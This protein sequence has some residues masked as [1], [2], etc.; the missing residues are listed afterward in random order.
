MRRYPLLWPTVARSLQ[1]RWFSSQFSAFDNPL[2]RQLNGSVHSLE[3][4]PYTNFGGLHTPADFLP[5]FQQTKTDCL[6]IM[7]SC[8]SSSSSS[9]PLDTIRGID[10]VSDRICQVA[11][12]A[13]LTHALHTDRQWRAAASEIEMLCGDFI[14]SL[15]CHPSI[16]D[17][18]HTAVSSEVLPPVAA[19]VGHRLKAELE[20]ARLQDELAVMDTKERQLAAEYQRLALSP[21]SSLPQRQEAL[22]AL[23][24]HRQSYARARSF[25][26]YAEMSHQSGGLVYDDVSAIR[27][28]MQ[29]LEAVPSLAAPPM[30]GTLS[31][32]L[33][34]PSLPLVP[35]SSFFDGMQQLCRQMLQLDVHLCPVEDVYSQVPLWAPHTQ[36][37]RVQQLPSSEVSSSS[38]NMDQGETLGYIYVDLTRRGSNEAATYVLRSAKQKQLLPSIGNECQSSRQIPRC[39]LVLPFGVRHL[40]LREMMTACHEFGHALHNI[41]GQTEFQSMAGTRC[42]RD[43]VEI[44]ST[45]WE[46]VCGKA[47]VLRYFAP[48][49]SEDQCQAAASYLDQH[50][51]RSLKHSLLLAQF[52]M[53]LH[54]EVDLT[55]SIDRLWLQCQRGHSN[56]GQ[57]GVSYDFTRFLHIVAYPSTYYAYVLAAV[58]AERARHVHFGEDLDVKS[59]RDAG[60][61]AMLSVGGEAPPSDLLQQWRMPVE[62]PAALIET[63]R[64]ASP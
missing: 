58:V 29:H 26:S 46:R 16:H 31:L 44:P 15:N 43:F 13:S 36:V 18:L 28:L 55:T 32:P 56:P 59:G 52:D 17:A 39:A 54:S 35:L 57:A 20:N 6:G 24:Q 8:V 61:V 45:V 51:M 7:N 30:G 23:V 40:S 1:Y 34:A 48:H 10:T 33:E 14:F 9:S 53:D 62:D 5:L 47:D 49:W 38:S 11:D 2:G 12:C 50:A 60:F 37:L 3:M 63:L 41:V 22:T 25:S 4:L 42:A 64:G 27:D 21:A 19:Y